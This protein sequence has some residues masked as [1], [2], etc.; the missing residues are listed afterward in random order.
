MRF[1]G[2]PAGAGLAAL[3]A[4][5]VAKFADELTTEAIA[6]HVAETNQ[7]L[8][9]LLLLQGPGEVDPADKDALLPKLKTW[10]NMPKFRGRLASEAS[11]RVISLLTSGGWASFPSNNF[12]L[13][14]N[15][16]DRPEATH[17]QMVKR[18][19]LQSIHECG[20]PGCQVSSGLQRCSR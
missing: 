6:D 15:L 14:L 2:S 18:M 11:D 5:R 3:H 1:L 12:I 4:K 9:T 8:S 16:Y 19:L 20:A 17:M 7:F 13:V 10:K